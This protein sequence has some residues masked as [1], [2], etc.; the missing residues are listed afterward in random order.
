MRVSCFPI[1]ILS[2][3]ALIPIWLCE[4]AMS[5][6]HRRQINDLEMAWAHYCETQAWNQNGI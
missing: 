3:D 2:P 1:E 5:I 6:K 4:N